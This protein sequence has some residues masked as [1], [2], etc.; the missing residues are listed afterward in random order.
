MLADIDN[1]CDQAGGVYPDLFLSGHAHSIQRYTRTKNVNGVTRKIP[2]L[3]YGC[4]GHGGQGI[5]TTFPVTTGDHTYEFGYK[6]YGYALVTVTAQSVTL[7]AYGV[8]WN[9][10][11]QAVKTPVDK[12]VTVDLT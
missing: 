3:I 10:N 7:N 5:G 11:N 2:H 6:G 9:A 1:A 12:P 4:L 8:D